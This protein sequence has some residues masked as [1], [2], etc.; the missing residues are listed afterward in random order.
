M[1]NDKKNA[2]FS[3]IE[4][5]ITMVIMVVALGIVS[6]VL[7]RAMNVRSRESQTADALASARAAI[8]VM[9]REIANSGFGLYIPGSR[10]PSNG[11]VVSE[12]DDHR[13]RIRSNIFNA[14]GIATAPGPETLAINRPGEDVTYF[15]DDETRSIVRF[16]PFGLETAPGV[17]GPQ[18]SVVVNRISNVTFEYYD[19]AG[20]TSESTGPFTVPTSTTARVKIIVSVELDQ[21]FGQ[22]NTEYV[23]FASDV[24]FRNNN[25]MLSQY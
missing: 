8:S 9:S 17:Y 15:F 22:P 4:L 2:G 1:R 16:D 13:I 11:L 10:T 12:S 14:G 7:S 5:M 18:T 24:T 3:L 23:V 25:Y 6:T 19:Y 21:V 20:G